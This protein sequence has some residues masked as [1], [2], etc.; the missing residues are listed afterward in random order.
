MRKRN[1]RNCRREALTLIELLVV[2]AILGILATVVTVNVIDRLKEAKVAKA[3]ADIAELK[4]ALQFYKLDNGHYPSSSEGLQVLTQKTE[5]QPNGYIASLPKDP[6]GN[7]Y[8]YTCPGLHGPFD[9]VSYGADGAQG[10]E[11]DNADIESW[12]LHEEG[13][14]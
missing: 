2:V 7:E 3:K 9:I 13:G 14:S 11:G 5:K 8:E 1:S 10:G 12:T 6:W 4:T